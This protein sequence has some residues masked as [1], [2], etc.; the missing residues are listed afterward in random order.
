MKV[1]VDRLHRIE[2]KCM[3]QIAKRNVTSTLLV[4]LSQVESLQNFTESKQMKDN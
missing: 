2:V 3:S 4:I 1:C